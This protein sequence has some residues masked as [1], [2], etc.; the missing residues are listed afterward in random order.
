M[1]NTPISKSNSEKWNFALST[2][3]VKALRAIAVKIKS[4]VDKTADTVSKAKL[5]IGLELNNARAIMPNDKQ[6]GEWA[7]VNTPFDSSST[8]NPLMHLARA[9]SDGVLTD[10]MLDNSSPAV[11]AKIIRLPDT[12]RDI[13]L[14]SVAQGDAPRRDEVPTVAEAEVMED[15]V[16]QELIEQHEDAISV[17]P[18]ISTDDIDAP[19]DVTT[20]DHMERA[21]E[22]LK[23]K[24]ASTPSVVDKIERKQANWAEVI[25]GNWIERFST[26]KELRGIAT[27]L[28]C[29]LAILGFDPDP[30]I[31][32]NQELVAVWCN[33]LIQRDVDSTVER[34][35][36]ENAESMINKMRADW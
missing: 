14:E 32:P 5:T 19:L 23:K 29:A 13:L 27:D 2:A 15:E 28:E 10:E 16:E 1:S 21:K 36:V 3:D 35:A 18:A 24:I 9:K 25:G 34:M 20:E 33:H 4:T 7:R 31:L 17:T 26:V 12:T 30:Q 6:F 11:L 22:A 8:W